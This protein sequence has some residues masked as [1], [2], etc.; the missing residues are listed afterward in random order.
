M[1][2]KLIKNELKFNWKWT[3][4][5][6]KLNWKWVK[7]KLRVKYKFITNYKWTFIG[8]NSTMLT[9]I[10]LISKEWK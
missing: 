5:E 2:W 8:M 1:N 3:K 10:I 9:S 7:F 6:S 4:T